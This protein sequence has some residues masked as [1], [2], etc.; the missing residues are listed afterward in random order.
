MANNQIKRLLDFAN[1]QMAAE[2]FLLRDTDNG[3]IPADNVIRDRLENGNFHASVFTPTQAEKFV[4]DYQVLTQYR[5]DPTLAG[6]TGFSGTLFKNK[7]TGELTLSF[8]S[9][10]FI[11][12][13]VRDSKATNELEI[14]QLGW[15]LGQISDMEK[16]YAQLRTDPKLLGG[17][18]FNVTGYSLGGHLATAFNILRREEAEAGVSEDGNPIIHTYTF[19][20][21]GVGEYLNGKRLTDIVADFRR[22]RDDA[23][24]FSSSVWTSLSLGEQNQLRTQAQ[25]RVDTI[26]S[27]RIRV[28]GLETT[29]AF[30]T[31]APSGSQILLQYQVAALLAALDTT[32]SSLFF[33]PDV[34]TVPTNPK[35]ADQFGRQRISNMTEV[36]GSDSGKLG[37]SWVSNSGIHYGTRQE[38]YIEDQPL[39]RG[40]YSL[41]LHRGSLISNPGKNDFA[42][43]HSLV[44]VV[45]SLALMASLET[46]D[47]QITP[48]VASKI[49]AA[50]SNAKAKIVSGAD[51]TAEGDTLEKTLD[52]IRLL[53]L[54]P[55]AS[56]TLSDL[57]GNTWHKVDPLRNSFYSN[58]NALSGN[59]LFKSSSGQISFK[60]IGE[61]DDTKA[62]AQADIA[63]RY[64]L[65]ELNPYAATGAATLYSQ[66][67]RDKDLLLYDESTGQ[68]RLT[69]EWLMDRSKFLAWKLVVNNRN[70][71]GAPPFNDEAWKFEDRNLAQ[72]VYLTGPRGSTTDAPDLPKFEFNSAA[73]SGNGH[74]VVFGLDASPFTPNANPDTAAGGKDSLVGGRLDDRLYGGG[75]ND[76]LRGLGGNDYLEGGM[77]GDVLDGGDG[78]DILRG[79]H[80]ADVLS[81][82]KGFDTYIWNKGDAF[83]SII[84]TREGTPSLSKGMIRFLGQSLSGNK[85]LYQPDNPSLFT[86]D[87]GILYA[88]TGA[89]DSTGELTIV[90]PNEEGGLK[91]LDFRN[92]D[93]GITLMPGDPLQKTD[94]L[95]D[96][97]PNSLDTYLYGPLFKLFGLGGPD[98]LRIASSQSE[99]YGGAGDDYVTDGGG[100]SGE[101]GGNSDDQYFYG[102]EGDDILTASVGNDKL[103]GGTGNDAL[104]GGI[105]TDYLSGD[106]GNDL[107]SGGAGA[108]AL[109]GGDGNDFMFGDGRFIALGYGGH[110]VL[111]IIDARGQSWVISHSDD[112]TGITYR[113]SGLT[114]QDQGDAADDDDAI[115]GGAGDDTILAGSG[116]DFIDSGE[117]KDLASGDAGADTLFGGAGDD[118]L[119]G[120]TWTIEGGLFYLVPEL[121]G[122]DF[123]DGEAGDDSLVGQ[124]GS[125]SLY[126]GEG[127]DILQGDQ[128]GL[129]PDYHGEDYIEGGAGADKIYGQGSDDLLFGGDGDD[130][131][132]GDQDVL[133]G[134]YHG[135][136]FI[137]G[138]A[139]NDKLVGF[140]G[141]D[142]I[143]GSEG[144]DLIAGDYE[145]LAPDFH[146]DDYLDGGAGEDVLQ[147]QGGKD[148][149]FGGEGNDQL[150][151]GDGND[152]LTGGLGNDYLGG[153]AGDDTYIFASGDGNDT[154]EDSEGAADRLKFGTGI[155]KAGIVSFV[156][157]N[158]PGYLGIRYSTTD[159]IALKG[160]LTGAIEFVDYAD[161]SSE[162][163]SQFIG[164][165]LQTPRN[166]QGTSG[167]DNLFGGAASDALTGNGGNDTF[168]G[169]KGS[170]VITG[171]TGNDLYLFNPGDGVDRIIDIASAGAGNTLRFG[172]GILPQQISI[173]RGSLLINVGDQGDAIH[174]ET[175]DPAD[176]LGVH[177]IEI[178]EFADGT[179]LTYAEL[180]GFGFDI[181]GTDLPELLVG[182]NV[183]DR[184]TGAGGDDRLLGEQGT[185]RL[186]GGAGNDTLEGGA[187]SDTYIGGGEGQDVVVDLDS[188]PGEIDTLSL[189]G[190]AADYRFERDANNV[191]VTSLADP[192]HVITLG[193]AL[194]ARYR[195]EQV[196]FSDGT[197]WDHTQLLANSTLIAP[198]GGITTV[199]GSYG[200]DTVTGT[201]GNDLIDGREGND[202]LAGG[203]G[204]DNLRDSAGGD[205]RYQF[206]AGDGQDTVVDLAGNDRIEFGSG[207]TAGDIAGSYFSDASGSYLKLAYNGTDVVLI[208]DGLNG[209]M[210]TFV[211]GDGQTWDI[212]SFL[213]ATMTAGMSGFVPTGWTTI[214][215][216]H[217]NDSLNAQDSTGM[218][219]FGGQG[220]DSMRGSLLASDTYHFYRGDGRDTILET[221][222]GANGIVFGPGI[223]VDDLRLSVLSGT[224][225]VIEYAP[226]DQ[227][228][229]GNG[230]TGVVKSIRF[231]DGTSLD[232]SQIQALLPTIITGTNGNDI[233][234]GTEGPNQLDGL[235]GND[236]LNGFGG[237]D[238]LNGGA[239]D[240]Q[241]NGGAGHDRLFGGAGNDA[242]AGGPGDDYY[243]VDV[244]GDS[245]TENADEGYDFVQSGPSFV[246]G[247]NI[248]DLWLISG[249]AGTGNDLAN[250]II[251]NSADNTLLGLGGNDL[252]LGDAGNDTL[253]GGAGDDVL[254]AAD[255]NDV[256][257]GGDGADILNA[258]AGNDTLDGGAGVDQ[259]RGG[260]G[261]DFYVVD[262]LGDLIVELPG[263][264]TDT[265]QA[266]LDF[267]LVAAL[268]NLTLTGAAVTG[269]GNASANV[270]TG[271]AGNNRLYGGAGGDTISGGYGA[272][273][274]YGEA[275]N[276]TL[277]GGN[278]ADTLAGGA[279]DDAAN[280]GAGNDTYL[281]N[282][283]DGFDTIVDVDATPGNLDILHIDALRSEVTVNRDASH[284]YLTIN[285]TG[286]K[287]KLS[288]HFTGGVNARIE[289]VRF[290]DGSIVD[291]TALTIDPISGT[292]G[293]DV[294]FGTTVADVINGLGGNDE[295]YANTG[296]DILNGGTGNDKLYGALGN[297]VLNG[298]A[299]DDLLH[300]GPDYDAYYF[301]LGDGH[302]E[303]QDGY[304]NEIAKIDRLFFGPGI[305]PEDIFITRT[306]AQGEHLTLHVSGSDSVLL[307]TLSNF[308]NGAPYLAVDQVFFEDSTVWNNTAELP[309]EA[310]ADAATEG[311]DVIIGFAGWA[312]TIHGL[313]G[314]DT[315]T[316]MTGADL[317]FGGA[318]NDTLYGDDGNDTLNGGMGND[319]LDGGAGNDQ[320]HGGAGDDVFFVDSDT[321]AV[322]EFAD[323]G[324]DT[325]QTTVSRFIPNNVE[326][327]VL[328]GAGSINAGGNFDN[329]DFIGNA[330]ANIFTDTSGGSDTY[331][332]G[333]GAGNDRIVEFQQNVGEID[334]V[335]I[336]AGVLLEELLVSRVGNDLVLS[337]QGATDTMALANWFG[338]AT[339]LV[340]EVRFDNGV[341]WDAT[342]LAH[343]ASGIGNNAPVLANALA[344]QSG[345]EDKAFSFVIPANAFT[346]PDAG[347]VLTYSAR[348]AD[349]S[350][351]P[352]WM[353]FNAGTRTLSGTPANGDVG[354]L[355]VRVTATDIGGLSVSDVFN[356]TVSNVNDAP[357][358]S[359]AIADLAATEDAAFSFTLPAN[360]FA[361][362]D[363]GDTLT[364]SATR[365]DG[366]ALPA[367]LTFNMGTR[368][369]SGTPANGDVGTVSLKVTAT[370]VAGA[371]VT[372][373]FELAVANTNGAP[374]LAYALA[375][376]AAVEDAPF[377]FTVPANTFADIDTGDTLSYSATR[378]D[379]SALPGWLAF[380][381]TTRTFSGTPVN[382]DAGALD[383]KVT[384]TDAGG[385]S[386]SGGFSVTVAN[387]NDAPVLANA[388][389]D[390]AVNEDAAFSFI[391]PANTFTDVDAGDSLTCS[392]TRADCSALPA[393]LAFNAATRTFSGTP[394]NGDVG[395]VSLLVTATDLAG[396]AVAEVFDLVVANTNDAPS[397]VAALADRSATEDAAFSFTVPAG[398]FADVDTGDTLTT[399][400]NLGDGSALPGWLTYNAST[401]TFSGTP[402]NGDVGTLSLKVTATDAAGA[403]A[404]DT[405]DLTV[406]NTNDAPTL[407]QAIDD[408]AA[409]EDAAFS[410]TVPA[411]AFA[412][413]D[414]GDTLAFSAMR[415]DGS[416][417][418]A[419][420]AFNAATRMFSG[421][422]ANSDVGALEVRV[423]ATDGAGVSVTDDFSLTVAN[424]ND[425]PT[426]VTAL[427]DQSANAESA[428]NFQFVDDAFA[429]IDAGDA[430]TYS[431]HLASGADLPGWLTFNPATRSFSGTPGNDDAG[432]VE[433]RVMATDGSGAAAS[434]VFALTVG[435]VN[436]A[437]VVASPIADLNTLEDAALS[438]QVPGNTFTDADVGDTLTYAATREDGSALPAWLAFN[439]ATRT[440]SGTPDNGQ[441]GGF[442]IK[443]TTTD[444]GGLSVADS[445]DL[446]VTNVNDAP[447]LV[448]ALADQSATEDAAFSFTLLAGS[449]TDVD[450]S[451]VLSYAA[452]RADGS[453]LPAWL[454]FNA[455]TL[456]FSGTPANADVGNLSVR[457]TATDSAGAAVSDVFDLTVANVNDAPVLATVIADQAATEDAPFGFTVPAGAFTDV[458]AGDTLAFTATLADGSALPGWLAFNAGSRT[459]SGTPA[460]VNVGTLSIKVVATDGTGA[461]AS[462]VFDLT[463]GNSN[464]APAV[465]APLADQVTAEDA[466]FTFVIPA[467]TFA[468]VDAGDTLAYAATSGDGSALPG[469]LAFDAASRTLIGTPGNAE[470]G[471]L[472]LRVT[473]TDLSGLSAADVFD[474]TIANVNDAP[475]LAT[476]LGDQA[477]TEDAVFSFSVPAAAFSDV[478]AGD[479]LTL[480]ASLAGGSALPAW[481]AF[482]AA[483]GTF[484]GTPA[485]GDVGSFSLT[486][487][488]TDSAGAT[489]SD[490][491]GLTVANTN[492]A[493][494]VAAPLADQTTAEDVPFALVIP[495]GTFV[496][497]DA[498]DTLTTTVTLGNGSALPGWLSFN[499]ATRT[500]EGTP[501]NA[502]IGTVSLRV[503][504]TD[505]AGANATD[506]FD[507]TVTNVNDAPVLATAI[508]DQSATE[509]AA[510]SFTL[511]A[512]TFSDVD[513]GDTLT[514]AATLG[515]AAGLP[516]W[517]TFNP[518]TRSFAGTPANG[519]V[520]SLTLKVTATDAAGATATGS[521]NLSVANVND[522]PVLAAAVADQSAVAGTGFSFQFAAGTFTDPDTGDGLSYTAALVAGGTLPAWLVFNAAARTFEGTPAPVDAGELLIRLTAVDNGGLTATD[523]F[524][525]TVQG[526][527]SGVTLIGTA[528][529]DALLGGNG[530]DLL[531]GLAGA[532]RLTGSEGNDTFRYAR[533]GVWT[534]G[535]VAMNVG[536]PGNPGTHRTAAIAGKQRSF[537]VFLGG[538]GYDTL[539][540]TAADDAIFLDDLYSPFYANA[541]RARLESVERI[542]V[543]EG[544]DVVDLT[545]TLYAHGDVT[546]EGGAGNDVLWASSGNDVLY[547]ETGND[548]LFGGAGNDFLAG[549]GGNDTLNGDR[550]NDLL[551]GDAGNDTL[552][553]TA[554]A[555][556]FH[557]GAGN[558]SLTGG[559]G[560]EL[561][562]GGA[563]NDTLVTGAGR[564]LVAFNRGD[565][566]DTVTATS[567]A[568]A[569]TTLSLGGGIGYADLFLKRSGNNLLLETGTGESLAFQGW[570]SDS[571]RRGVDRLQTIA[572]AMAGFD[573]S[574][575]DP[576]KDDR[577]EA[578]DFKVLVQKFDQARAANPALNRWA[579]TGALLNAHLGGSDTEALGGDL[580]YRYGLTGSLA[581]TGI[582]P[583]Q[584]ILADSRFGSTAQ[585]LQPPAG[586]QEGL[587]RLG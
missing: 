32:A 318:G 227:V 281:F 218:R 209:S 129:D 31:R 569:G 508:S 287:V 41:L 251:G 221:V 148:R 546:I 305:T 171:G 559:V 198:A 416:A 145:T 537:D 584:G 442:G 586:L 134:Q 208:K 387:V 323:E 541:K 520:G 314:N 146:G 295:L 467:G 525:L 460:N 72:T 560:N 402:A 425:A 394:A 519:D 202:T 96:A 124:G 223:T 476:A 497:V 391:V 275:G 233:L 215:T 13:A 261:N 229:I 77:D 256:L 444:A 366:S 326:R 357:T 56:T 421:T 309:R 511:P 483:T 156:P 239:N 369:F 431:A 203:A 450:A 92:G 392:A 454:A 179:V 19:N 385:L 358:V 199:Y 154:V 192:T 419:W 516:A 18:T 457:L 547:G 121:H 255:G 177:A 320:F 88:F 207:L 103:F 65:K 267:T 332:F 289:K 47:P 240:D 313:G 120:D 312:D 534:G 530:D 247:P 407:S 506:T 439:A 214:Y 137:D 234:N 481:L 81:G 428:F 20:G 372:D 45:D 232:F 44:L 61:S 370:D 422:P 551:Q 371:N 381:A 426:L 110:D 458:D 122:D 205:D 2:A 105:G 477:A 470:V 475:V 283:G 160:G 395:S 54:G 362:V 459:F 383:L 216:G 73:L 307:T 158:Q 264:G 329:N 539:H 260:L 489:A 219:Y 316:G 132:S 436:H 533:D 301:N 441:V 308:T 194:Q 526:V 115:E 373:T 514:Y 252:L 43:T 552:T 346:D 181:Q 415:A 52:S 493:P 49:Y 35:Y 286:D 188:A 353:N 504:A 302:D 348:Q 162:T 490:T 151:G 226:G 191:I 502:D 500:I 155:S 113:F 111:P 131:I 10:E 434:D 50:A 126:G 165:T 210:E 339:A 390:Q 17:K 319:T 187:G 16:W 453:A 100:V 161:G 212:R 499:A 206:F 496:D 410:F 427:A 169:G 263:E 63:Y 36:V 345:P 12:D 150:E 532:D 211:T 282:L 574:G 58:L 119:F 452:T 89:M 566:Q 487:T 84:D 28:A 382:G 141:K 563:G 25:S 359:S 59:A 99:G 531:D 334:T 235:N 7:S 576:L 175:F 163:F 222:N 365:D 463:V 529:N 573:Q 437:P 236:T 125:D 397:V 564:D 571:S 272:D 417:L 174:L 485:N 104:Q 24:F 29:R 424:V 135:D 101:G 331:H 4:S 575:V 581:G 138:G 196:A 48:E 200:D 166:L 293:D 578:F 180:I 93:L 523:D 258:G 127:D 249:A 491:F 303:I 488:V 243:I 257:R 335:K 528:G 556:L 464:D 190:A 513:A 380:N 330:A 468:D 449:I 304:Y 62:L 554:G 518:V 86:D 118:R 375:D 396:A 398:M 521:F 484:S 38:I 248:E 510:F 356:L 37:P 116:D 27:E 432:T 108:D 254:E 367:W 11:D 324:I 186:D 505:G 368:T 389:A 507:L 404:S 128:E 279:G 225:I 91:I 3:V 545:S 413:V 296:N 268:E 474:L 342:V 456:A 536:S 580:A 522:A 15:A 524:K 147:G 297:D 98:I 400:A 182:T 405:F 34:N 376:Q 549:G 276:D 420:L 423:R 139:G 570:Y 184:I 109:S 351:L 269:I 550:G 568:G 290:R 57:N 577:I 558:D 80:D 355:S 75:G 360:S 466:P 386:A 341:V 67:G 361:D 230:T 542:V 565:G 273:E 159:T 6:G 433:V 157:E 274:L 94:L 87:N 66:F 418:P 106:E 322:T 242:M 473:A 494:A 246:L 557:A 164:R 266:S 14:K 462:D 482:D 280:G 102:E 228:S 535:F 310:L 70:S 60:P 292:E 197:L 583:A 455:A 443:I 168:S 495:A 344:D 285:A 42:D 347:D 39:V 85:T 55:T 291:T 311:D 298:N 388:L 447:T 498:G 446:T 79:G 5:N 178:F 152:E 315:L 579:V 173:S 241:M 176:T 277:N 587:V 117:G 299:G 133:A 379:G 271:N 429:D 300:G 572:E 438:Y 142:E 325:L 374:T 143:Y 553:D 265:V 337:I 306:G 107:L 328:T 83:D 172:V 231:D 40:N 204:N 478:D 153:D 149:L 377:G 201:A 288:D 561:L 364:Y 363:A 53:F 74:F 451:D 114:L 469:W 144:N 503:T 82:G 140:G 90:K 480:S 250:R 409:A 472:R 9:T 33:G 294:L 544:N 244:A 26:L 238:V 540:G 403:S 527:T 97:G 71:F 253:E 183:T 411:N 46:L 237:N 30:D 471:T 461:T 189:E 224:T 378:A 585:E 321:D 338:A 8:R 401:R 170:D 435:G 123:L 340:E 327:V 414:V 406:A 515:N 440:L 167:N 130:E 538:A 543:G 349:G 68:G 336:D 185:D 21:A 112:S 430:L 567:Q 393:W 555:N 76:V 270:L 193:N 284:L 213:N 22:Y 343:K 278:G 78:D 262:S 23:N 399:S 245:V 486:V 195:I 548:D 352:A 317:L 479:T 408:Q 220:N 582:A 384:A 350:A 51:G 333:R 448:T 412:D 562:I 217:G 69:D 95:G 64:A 1:M 517:L 465:A 354:L 259:L 501:G 512:A 445:F 136:D 509:D 492:D